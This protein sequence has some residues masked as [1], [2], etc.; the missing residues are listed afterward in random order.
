MKN[1]ENLSIKDKVYR[2]SKAIGHSKAWKQIMR[3]TGYG[4]SVAQKLSSGCYPSELH[5]LAVEALKRW[6]AEPV[7]KE[8]AS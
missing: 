1:A 3:V 4:E 5:P 8:E 2:K 6:V 7:S